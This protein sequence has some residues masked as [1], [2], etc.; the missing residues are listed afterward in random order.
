MLIYLIYRSISLSVQDIHANMNTCICDCYRW[1][2]TELGVHMLQNWFYDFDLE[3]QGKFSGWSAIQSSPKSPP[4]LPP[5]CV[6]IYQA[7]ALYPIW[8]TVIS[9]NATYVL[10]IYIHTCIIYIWLYMFVL[11]LYNS[12]SWLISIHTHTHI[13]IYIYTYTHIYIYI[14]TYTIILHIYIYACL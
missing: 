12:K 9:C 14:Y 10:Y 2:G 7:R 6:H 5:I 11:L 8:C 4:D 13:I 1:R 3:A